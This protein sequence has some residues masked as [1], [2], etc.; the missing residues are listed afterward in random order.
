MLHDPPPYLVIAMNIRFLE[1]QNNGFTP[2]T[3]EIMRL[4]RVKYCRHLLLLIMIVLLPCAVWGEKP[5]LSVAFYYGKQHP[6]NELRAFDIV[7]VDPDSGLSPANYGRGQSELFAYIS[8]GEADPARSYTKRMPDRWMIGENDAWK[9]KIV[10]VS[11]D[12][13][14][15]FFLEQVVEPLWQAGYRGFFLDTL[16]SYR[17]AVPAEAFPRMEAGLVA[18]VQD[19]RKRHPEARL[20][21][22]RGFEIFDR[23][24]DLVYAVAAESLFQTFNPANGKYGTVVADDR[25]WLTSRLSN[26]KGAGIP[27]IVIDYVNPGN[28]PLMRETAE[29]IKS[30]GFTP[31]V[32][33]KDLAGLGIGNVEVMP[34]TVLGLYDGGEGAGGDLYFTNLQRY[35]VMPLN[36]LGYTVEMHDMRQ[37]LP[38]GILRGRYAGAVVWPH[39]TISGEKQ[40]LKQWI[41]ECVAQGLPLVFLERF[42]IS[43]DS[44]LA[45]S[46]NLTMENF[47]SLVPPAKVTAKDDMVGFEQQPLPRID[48]YLPVRAEKGRVLL[49]LSTANGVTS[50]AVAITPWGGYVSGP[51]VVTQLM[52]RQ[53]AWVIDP[54]RFFSEA[55]KLPVMP[56]PDTTTENGVRLLLAHVD[57]DGFESRAEWPGGKL[58]SEELRSNILERYRIPTTVSL[59]TSTLAPDGLYPQKSARYEEIA[60]GILALPWVEGA[61]HSFSHPFRWKPD[62]EDTGIEVETWHTVNIPGYRF[63]LESEVAGSTQYIN[64]R[65]MPA[66]KKARMFLW[67][68]NCLPTEDAVRL[69]YENGLLNIN[70]GDTIIT[71]SN[72]SLT[73]VA[74]L[75]IDR[76]TWFQVFAPNQNENVYTHLWSRDFYGYRRV[77]ETFRLTDSPRRLKPVNI[78]YHFYSASKE[79]SLSALRKVY[80]WA[81]DQRLFATFTSE[82]AERVLDFNRTVIARSGDEWLVRNGGRLRQL[83]IPARAGFPLLED[84]TNLAGYSDLGENRYLHM[85]PGGEARVRLAVTPPTAVSLQSAAARLTDFTRSGKNIRISLTGHTPFSVDL[86]G[87]GGCSIKAGNTTLDAVK[88]DITIT[89]K[90]GSHALAI[91]C[92]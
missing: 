62:Q 63:N 25:S 2:K 37:P 14:R 48:A 67:T 73:A 64:E 91:T 45:N 42:G 56:V 65:L 92:K 38:T 68:G 23:V 54:F 60:R 6:V 35:V 86:T 16:D 22:N 82:Y 90:E 50:D 3:I 85:G 89:L 57:G 61:S 21:L 7:V 46:L 81:M 32:T 79:A 40:G 72:R 75:G 77:I 24:K 27:V 51:Y 1:M 66:G 26:I 80:D 17:R 33:D 70:G 43:I 34:R 53:S 52:E 58:A 44:D 5:P 78:Y 87:A 49:Q 28:R 36:Y 4:N 59:I 9:S 69:T 10:D 83:R 18:A 76:G 74:P 11:S 29:K 47:A 20:I 84:D 13:W 71:D 88:G 30:L 31:W 8:V 19:I 41:L 39:S 12:E 15:R 55:L